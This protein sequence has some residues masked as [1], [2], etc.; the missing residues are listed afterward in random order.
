MKSEDTLVVPLGLWDHQKKNKKK[1]SHME[2][3][4]SYDSVVE[5]FSAPPHFFWFNPTIGCFPISE[6]PGRPFVQ[7]QVSKLE[8]EHKNLNKRFKFEDDP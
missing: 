4:F 8:P 5:F 3:I 6:R 7:V 2:T 1:K